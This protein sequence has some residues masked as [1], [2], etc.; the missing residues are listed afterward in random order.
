MPESILSII[1]Y[2]PILGV[3]IIPFLKEEEQVKWT[4]L[5]ITGFTFILS[6]PLLLAFDVRSSELQFVHRFDWI[7]KKDLSIDYYLG[8]DGVALLLFVL[9]SFL[10]FLSSAA[11]WTYISKRIKEFYISLLLLEVGVLGVFAAANLVLFYVFWEL[12]LIPMALMIGVWGGE[13]RLY[14]AIKFFIYTMAGSV[15]MLAAILILYFKANTVNI[16]QLSTLDLNLLSKEL[17]IFLFF[18]FALSFAIKIPLFPLHTWLPDAHTEAPTAGSVILAGVLLKMGTYGFIRFCIPFFPTVALEYKELLMLLSVI[19]I[20]Y[21]ALVAMVQADAKKLIAYS[22]VSHLGFCT[23]GLM[24]FTEEGVM[25]GMI[26][27]INHGVSTGMLFLL[28]GMIYERTHTRMIKDYGGI[29]KVVPTFAIFF[30]IA[31]L[32]SVGLPGMN[33]FV[34]EFLVLVGTLKVNV[35]LGIIAGTGVIWAAG[36]LLYLTKRLLFG[37]LTNKENELLSDLNSREIAILVPLVI[38]IFWLGVYPKT[39]FQYLE[40]SLKVYLNSASVQAIAE[41]TQSKLTEE[42]KPAPQNYTRSYK[43]LGASPSSTEERLGGYLGRFAIYS[44]KTKIK[45]DSHPE[46]HHDPKAHDHHEN[47]EHPNTEKHEEKE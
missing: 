15:L 20:V 4:S 3:L 8:L 7:L 35:V 44:D 47:P 5:I 33:G 18:A 21:G 22:S 17:Q 31:M 23:L 30:V 39:F 14:A 38:L 41:R 16:E 1:I 42:G 40:P 46:H 34:G 32:S 2:F 36:Y 6:I 45:H 19:G 25:G 43:S 27:M 12:M 11:S 10:F 28:I 26:Q 13:N 9:T 29:A 24:T 37:E